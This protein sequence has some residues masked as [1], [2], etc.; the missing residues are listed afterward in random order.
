MVSKGVEQRMMR[1]I[2]DSNWKLVNI[3]IM[4]L[5]ILPS[6]QNIHLQRNVIC[7]DT[8]A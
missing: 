8:I 6:Q 7:I 2:T 3:M 5:R 4:I 1:T